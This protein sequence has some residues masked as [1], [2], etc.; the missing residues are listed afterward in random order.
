MARSVNYLGEG[1]R[2]CGYE[3]CG[4]S[5]AAPVRLTDLSHKPHSETYYACPHCFSKMET[6]DRDEPTESK[7]MKS[8]DY[9]TATKSS[10]KGTKT[11][12]P[13]KTGDVAPVASCPYHVGYLKTRSKSE[14][15]PDGCLTCSKILECMV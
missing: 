2:V 14:A 12:A 8:E 6:A 9:E 3:R 13:K 4:K 11:K 7:L 5:F 10:D 1:L 15:V